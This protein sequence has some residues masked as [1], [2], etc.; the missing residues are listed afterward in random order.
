MA[1]AAIGAMACQNLQV[2][3]FDF[4][5]EN[6]PGNRTYGDV[7]T[8]RWL[9][10][11]Q[12]TSGFERVNVTSIP[13]KI[14]GVAFRV[15]EPQCFDVA[16]TALL[17]TDTAT[18][19]SQTPK[20]MVYSFPNDPYRIV[21]GEDDDPGALKIDLLAMK[22]FC[23]VD[24]YSW[25]RSQIFD[26]LSRFEEG[27]SKSATELLSAAAGTTFEGEAL[28]NLPMFVDYQGKIT[29]NPE[30]EFAMDQ[31]MKDIMVNKQFSIIGGRVVNKI[32]K[33]MEWAGLDAAGIDLSKVDS[34]IPYSFYDRNADSILGIY[35]WLQ[36]AP[37]A[38]Q[39]VTW[40][41]YGPGS[42]QRSEVTD[43]YSNGTITMPRTGLQIDWEWTYDNKCKV[44]RFIP[45]LHMDVVVVPPGGCSTPGV[46]G[47]IRVHDC[48]GKPII[49]VCPENPVG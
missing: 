20:E 31:I 38:A 33:Y 32:N 2:D 35:D 37:G 43:L 30:A 10:S 12:N 44:W 21:V 47:I 14:R 39:I 5:G 8:L 6:I 1:F 9:L 40:N 4:F 17:C 26:V 28:Q 25:I 46:N 13:G 23:T 15:K 34:R 18:D 3:L 49:P 29:V 7:S 42:S 19:F 36:L 45:S 24:D 22:Q 11:P 16:R 48:S 27:V 41:Q